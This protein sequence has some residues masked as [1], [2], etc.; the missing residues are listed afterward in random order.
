MDSRRATSPAFSHLLTPN[1]RPF[2]V[3]YSFSP[4]FTC[5]CSHSALDLRTLATFAINKPRVPV[6][7]FELS[8]ASFCFLRSPSQYRSLHLSSPP[9]NICITRQSFRP[10]SPA[11]I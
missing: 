11:Y 5:H 3:S 6:R 4:F 1:H 9:F 7:R 10:S 8:T 2:V